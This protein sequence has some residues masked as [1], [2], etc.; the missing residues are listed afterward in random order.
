MLIQ[1][2]ILT[3]LLQRRPKPSPS[4]ST[5]KLNSSMEN[6]ICWNMM[7]YSFHLMYTFIQKIHDLKTYPLYLHTLV[8]LYIYMLPI[9]VVF[10]FTRSYGHKLESVPSA[11]AVGWG[12]GG[13]NKKIS[14]KHPPS[15]PP[16]FSINQRSQEN[17]IFHAKRIGAFSSTTVFRF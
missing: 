3:P 8:L 11:T 5:I 14:E 2:L 4:S 10:F 16:F 12:G 6:S 9:Q 7:Q 1:F 15:P 17:I 13:T